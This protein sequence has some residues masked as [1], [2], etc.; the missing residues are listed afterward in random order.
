MGAV[1]LF[2]Y[3]IPKGIICGGA[4]GL[5]P[6]V[7][8]SPSH[9]LFAS[10]WSYSG[11]WECDRTAQGLRQGRCGARAT[12]TKELHP[13]PGAIRVQSSFGPTMYKNS[14]GPMLSVWSTRSA[15]CYS[16]QWLHP[17]NKIKCGQIQIKKLE[18]LC[19]F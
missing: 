3:D 15:T 12:V 6:C 10:K 2:H 11:C 7:T 1:Q 13:A 17:C 8:L 14:D 9:M 18:G 19:L 5:P 4:P 16:S